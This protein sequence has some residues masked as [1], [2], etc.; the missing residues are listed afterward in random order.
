MIES[1]YALAMREAE[2]AWTRGL[3]EEIASGSLEGVEEWASSGGLGT[4]RRIDQERDEP[5]EGGATDKED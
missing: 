1:E 4:I 3:L 5:T 2:L